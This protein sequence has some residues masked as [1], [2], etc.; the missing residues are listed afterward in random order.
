MSRRLGSSHS[1]TGEWLVQRV[2]SLYLAGFVVFLIIRFAVVPVGDYAAWL[3]LWRDPV[4]RLLWLTFW[5]SLLLHAWVGLRSVWMDYVH[6]A[7]LRFGV[8]AV[9]AL[10]LLLLS[11]WAARLILFL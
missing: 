1:G 9:T 10:A 11:F 7:G 3:S 5:L 2:T 6:P 4:L 8:L